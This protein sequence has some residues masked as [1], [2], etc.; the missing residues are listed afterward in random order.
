MLNILDYN[1]ESKYSTRARVS[2][3]MWAS[4]SSCPETLRNKVKAEQE[5]V[6]FNLN[7]EDTLK[8]IDESLEWIHNAKDDYGYISNLTAAC[9]D[10]YTEARNSGLVISLSQ[11]YLRHIN[12]L[13]EQKKAEEKKR[14][15]A[16][17]DA[18]SEYVGEVG[19]RITFVPADAVHVSTFE[20]LY[21]LVWLYKFTDDN[22]NVYIW[23]SS[24][25]LEEDKDIVSV[26]GTV[27]SHSEY[28]DVK[29]T[30]LTRC[31]IVYSE[32]ERAE[33]IHPESRVSEVE[34]AV[35]DFIDYVNR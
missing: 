31:K 18:L 3:Y 30:V 29:Q 14:T 23:Y 5:E 2:D 28:R 33:E 19:Q 25:P 27:K 6:G 24:N 21:G 32:K 9:L 1:S 35:A 11:A 8:N 34:Q 10:D 20:N 17:L 22:N 15:Q 4:R 7:S 13:A 26:T 12:D 16:E